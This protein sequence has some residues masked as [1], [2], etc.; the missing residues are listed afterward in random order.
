MHQGLNEL[1]HT[2]LEDLKWFQRYK[3]KSTQDWII[4]QKNGVLHFRCDLGV[5]K[6]YHCAFHGKFQHLKPTNAISMT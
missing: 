2:W 6:L 1:F 5:S 3:W 4:I